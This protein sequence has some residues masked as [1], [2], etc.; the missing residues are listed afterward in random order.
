MTALRCRTGQDV[1]LSQPLIKM[2]WQFS[3]TVWPH[4]WLSQWSIKSEVKILTPSLQ[5]KQG[6][7]AI[8]IYFLT[9]TVHRFVSCLASLSLS[10]SLKW[11]KNC[12][13]PQEYDKV[14]WPHFTQAVANPHQ[15]ISYFLKDTHCIVLDWIQ[16]M[17]FP[18]VI[19]CFLIKPGMS[20]AIMVHHHVHCQNWITF[21]KCDVS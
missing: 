9:W 21:T 17:G 3:S 12:A 16:E 2:C 13:D 19:I 4:P 10:L 7:S 1:R 15:Q 20:M 6:N 14:P 18:Y 8:D 5:H 11:Y